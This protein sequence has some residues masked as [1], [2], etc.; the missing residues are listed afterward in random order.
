MQIKLFWHKIWKILVAHT[1][2][3]YPYQIETMNFSK[4]NNTLFFLTLLV[5]IVLGLRYFFVLVTDITLPVFSNHDHLIFDF[6]YF[7]HMG[8]VAFSTPQALYDDPGNNGTILL[9]LNRS[10]F[11]P[12]PPPASIFFRLFS[13]FPF[14]WAYLGWSLTIYLIIAISCLLFVK[15]IGN[16]ISCSRDMRFPLVLTLCAAPTFIDSSFGNVNSVMLLLCVLYTL[17]FIKKNY[18]IAGVVL[19]IAF[20]LKLYPVLLLLTVLFADK[21]LRLLAGFS[22]GVIFIFLIT[23]FILPISTFSD[24]FLTITPA[25]AQQ[26]LTHAFNQSLSATA[27]RLISG[28]DTYFAYNPV[29]TPVSIRALTFLLLASSII[30]VLIIRIHAFSAPL[31][32]TSAFICA[33]IPLIT[34]IGWGYTFVLTYP[35]LLVLYA[36]GAADSRISGIIYILCWFSLAIPSYHNIEK[37]GFPTLIRALYYSR[38]TLSTMVIA[39]WLL[40]KMFTMKKS[41]KSVQT[42]RSEERSTYVCP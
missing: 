35:A 25:Y 13:F 41:L 18:L 38:Y 5:F 19:S 40:I 27:L 7:Y 42:T 26:T 30:C 33:I 3:W 23:L 39:A 6:D 12:Y 32:A 11:H 24:F 17:S 22:S 1:R 31:V 15:C 16:Q 8:S 21:K 4:K 29:L 9:I 36:M 34:P 20:W 37:S 28:P 2:F 14:A 10:V